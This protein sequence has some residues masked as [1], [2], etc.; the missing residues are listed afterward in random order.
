MS[1][2]ETSE[3]STTSCNRAAAM[4][5]ESICCSARI[6]ATATEWET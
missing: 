2:T 4:V 6:V 3:S 5:T 1:S